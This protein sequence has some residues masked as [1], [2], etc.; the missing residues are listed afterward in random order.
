MFFSDLGSDIYNS[1]YHILGQHLKCDP[2]F[3]KKKNLAEENWVP[4]AENSGIL[5]EINNI[6]NRL[7][8][9]SRSLILDVDN[10]VCEQFNSV[11]NKYIGGKRVNLSQRNAYNARVEA[12]VIAF[13]SKEYLRA[14]MKNITNK[15]PGISL[16]NN[17]FYTY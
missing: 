9:N 7:V 15:S 3:C 8:L 11:I 5:L 2:Y 10:N 1:P 6:T 13:N 12:A 16:K 14:I 17:H 4:C